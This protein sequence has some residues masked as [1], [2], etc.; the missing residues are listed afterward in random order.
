MDPFVRPEGPTAANLNELVK[1]QTK[2]KI[3]KIISDWRP[4][5]DR[6][7]DSGEQREISNE[8]NSLETKL[9]DA[10]EEAFKG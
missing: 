7:V 4:H 1:L 9:L 5:L 10:L 2:L 6:A 8:V 3:M